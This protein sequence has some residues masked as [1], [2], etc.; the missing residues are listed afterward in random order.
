MTSQTITYL[1]AAFCD[2]KILVVDGKLETGATTA[3][4]DNGSK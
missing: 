4:S 1:V 2:R 3:P